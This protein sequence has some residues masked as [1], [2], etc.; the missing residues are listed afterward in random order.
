MESIRHA[1]KPYLGSR[2][3]YRGALAVMLPVT[4][5]QLINNLFNMIDNLMVGSLDIQGL[6]M[7]A[8]TV[9]NKPVLVYNGLV[10]GMVGAGGLLISQYFGS[11]D[12]RTCMGLFW[13]MMTLTVLTASLFFALL[14]FI[15]EQIMRIFV[16]DPTTIALGID[17]LRLAS[18]SYLPAAVSSVCI[19][20]LRS[21]GQN[22]TSMMVSLCSMGVNA[23]C[24]YLLIFGMLGFPQLGV[25]G[26]ALG[27]LIAR[28]FEMSVYAWL[29]LSHRMYFR[30]E[31]G[32]MLHLKR[33]ARRQ[34]TSK[35]IPLIIN[36][37]LYSI[38]FNIFFWYYARLD[39]VALP[40]LTIAELCYQIS[41]VTIMGN[42]SAVSVLIGKALGAGELDKARDHC[43]KLLTL[44]VGIS[45]IS[46]LLSA[47]LAFLMPQLYAISDAL[48][49]TATRITL[50]MAAFTP[51]RFVYIFCFFCLR[52][53]GDTRSAVLLDSGFLWLVP[54]PF[55][56]VMALAFPTS[57]SMPMAVLMVQLLMN[58]RI[59]PALRELAK[60]RWVRNITLEQEA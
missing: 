47:G 46:V 38:G 1:A 21:L 11:R 8:V 55:C 14:F 58:A 9:A 20:S 31:C 10:F 49:A 18:F 40:A 60:G 45:L 53:G 32:C 30:F 48:K 12:R 52:A 28:L 16:T 34:F 24:N 54:I 5:Q 29:L 50:I 33:N 42:S 2:S 15:P 27:T 3:F 56:L 25:R 6:A 41:M 17:Y 4:V 26:A 44:T 59:V 35:A 36:E 13:L 43:K 57:L 51:F 23:L 39:E 22:R 19:F 37:V 7:T